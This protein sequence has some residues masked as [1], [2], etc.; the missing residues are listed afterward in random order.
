M[1]SRAAAA[2]SAAEA[3]LFS[4]VAEEIR[5]LLHQFAA[6]FLKPVSADLLQRLLE[7]ERAPAV[8]AVE[9]VAAE[10]AAPVLEERGVPVVDEAAA[11][12]IL[13]PSAD[14]AAA[15]VEPAAEPGAGE[16]AGQHVVPPP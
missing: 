15:P 16:P 1:R 14:R 6:G 9:S 8:R 11:E 13:E 12:A 4:A 10:P 7:H 2:G 5:R 3:A